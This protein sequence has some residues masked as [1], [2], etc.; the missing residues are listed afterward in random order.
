ML[1]FKPT[2]TVKKTVTLTY[3]PVGSPAAPVDLIK[4]NGISF[5]KK[6]ESAVAVQQ[7]LGVGGLRWDVIALM[8]LS[9]SMD[10]FFH[11]GTVQDITERA[12]AWTA[13]VDADGMAPIGG[14]HTGFDWL[15]EVDLTNVMGI[16]GREGWHTA[17][18][19]NL[20]L[21]L[22]EALLVAREATNP[23]Y[24]FIVTDGA[25]N[26]RAAVVRLIQRMSQYPIF[27]KILLV[28]ND[29]G[30]HQFVDSLDDMQEG[31]LF[32][33]VD[34]QWIPVPSVVDDDNFNS[35]MTEE[36]ASAVQEMKS[37]GLVQ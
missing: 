27:I 19:T 3:N 35:M 17:G 5:E 37:V 20:A 33:N 4:K 9:Y 14:F 34:A 28:G 31:R 18:S 1:G 8:D 13:A 7:R 23:V 12:L 24:M 25:P 30:G 26:D 29:R 11:D 15:G 22:Q 21:G 36:L 2:L 16:V 32:D 6:V 10:P